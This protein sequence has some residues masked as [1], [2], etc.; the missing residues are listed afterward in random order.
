ML[1]FFKT[2]VCN[3]QFLHKLAVL[4]VKNGNFSVKWIPFGAREDNPV[5]D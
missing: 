4:Q 5:T 1:F 3:Y 2:N